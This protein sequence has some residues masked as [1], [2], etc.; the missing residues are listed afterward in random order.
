MLR[1]CKA[2]PSDVAHLC[3]CICHIVCSI[4]WAWQQHPH[5]GCLTEGVQR[6]H[7]TGRQGCLVSSVGTTKG[8]QG[9]GVRGKEM[10]NALIT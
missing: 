10:A 1:A 5:A 7:P 2:L 3:V 6:P 8:F 4:M 9:H